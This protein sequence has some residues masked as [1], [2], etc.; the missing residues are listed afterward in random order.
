MLNV[1]ITMFSAPDGWRLKMQQQRLWIMSHHPFTKF[2][3]LSRALL[4]N[5]LEMVFKSS[6]YFFS[7]LSCISQVSRFYSYL[8]TIIVKGRGKFLYK[9]WNVGR[10]L[11]D[12]FFLKFKFQMHNYYE[13]I[14]KRNEWMRTTIHVPFMF[15]TYI[16]EMTT[17]P[18]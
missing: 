18:P 4:K 1:Y 5:K 2:V 17:P 12:L 16:S 8:A 13:E 10:F 15:A 6:C 7:L 14:E 11:F 9:Y 3:L